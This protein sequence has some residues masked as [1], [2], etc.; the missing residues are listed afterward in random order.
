MW[1]VVALDDEKIIL[2]KADDKG[3]LIGRQRGGERIEVTSA[4]WMAQ[5]WELRFP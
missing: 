3:A 2:R 1:C 5:R 4:Q